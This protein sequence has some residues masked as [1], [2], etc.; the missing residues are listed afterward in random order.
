MKKILIWD[1]RIPLQNTGG[2]SG[3]LYQIKKQLISEPTDQIHFLSEYIQ[4][5]ETAL[6]IKHAKLSDISK[7]NKLFTIVR[8][9]FSCYRITHNPFPAYILNSVKI[10]EFTHIHFHLTV[11]YYNARHLLRN[12]KGIIV[13]TSHSPEPLSREIVNKMFNSN[14]VIA[15]LCALRIKAAENWAF[16]NA[17]K[18]MFPAEE[19]MEPYLGDSSFRRILLKRKSDIIFCPTAILPKVF[20]EDFIHKL[21][22]IHNIPDNAFLISYV[23]RHNKIKGYDILKN[24]AT[25]SFKKGLNIYFIIAGAPGY[26]SKLENDRW[27]EIGWTDKA[28]EI[29]RASDL[30]ILPNRETYFDLVA[31]EVLRSGCPILMSLTGGNKYFKNNFSSSKGIRFFYIDDIQQAIKEILVLKK[32][33]EEPDDWNALRESN[34]ELWRNN[35]TLPVYI[36]RYID[37]L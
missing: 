33:K 18:I 23:G 7:S 2:P 1:Y 29:I 36:K 16:R 5:P 21:R 19:A 34:I 24:I 26:L 17:D 15:K 32:L 28:N 10:N 35:F 11:D 14:S 25:E 31:L 4:E 9:I 30:F 3:Y 22:N 13:V 20:D 6:S 8:H 12:Y 37:I 27:I